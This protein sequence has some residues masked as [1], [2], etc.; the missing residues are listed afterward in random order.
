M[1][2]ILNLDWV[3][4]IFMLILS[5]IGIF[6][7][8]SISTSEI[9]GNYFTKEFTNQIVYNIIGIIFFLIFTSIPLIYFRIKLIL[10]TIYIVC[11]IAL[12]YTAIAGIEV[13]GVRRWIGIGVNISDDGTVYGG[14]T[15]Q[16]SE[17]AKIVIIVLNAYIL[18]ISSPIKEFKSIKLTTS[19]TNF[20]L[21]YKNYI[22][23]F[24]LTSIL[25]FSIYIQKSLSVT[26]VSIFIYIFM[27]MAT[28]SN[29][30]KLIIFLTLL[31]SLVVSN[32]SILNINNDLKIYL[33]ILSTVITIIAIMKKMF[34]F[35]SLLFTIAIGLAIPY[36]ILPFLWHKILQ[37]YQKQ[38][39]IAFIQPE[40]ADIMNEGYQ[41][42]HSIIS[43]GSGQLMGQGLTQVYHDR[44][45]L[46]P[47]PTT[48][49]IF[50]IFA[51]KFGFIGSVIL[52]SIYSILIL[53]LFKVA[54]EVINQ[55]YSLMII[56]INSMLIIQVFFNIGMN[57]GLLPVGGTTLPFISAGGS[58][59]VSM[60][61]AMGLAQNIITT[62][63][64]ERLNY[65][66]EDRLKISG[67]NISKLSV[68]AQ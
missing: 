37:D 65:F 16:P 10:I 44:V 43:V 20:F 18:S 27:V 32:Q 34:N 40:T 21:K 24:V 68:K 49:F 2:K 41:Q 55:Q 28:I 9:R 7:L 31:I 52:L 12:L 14:I 11:L 60:Y 57:I 36:L 59:L 50:A 53:R 54:D 26:L 15:I 38:R 66:R 45:L 23:S 56:G 29:K 61:M 22:Y 13:N 51:Y 67:W 58:S 63:K 42:Y 1:K 30:I 8:Y 5:M 4:F 33:L 25:I 46:L 48:D 47:E 62:F 3:I 39:I 6:T 17:F 35:K 19:L 64:S